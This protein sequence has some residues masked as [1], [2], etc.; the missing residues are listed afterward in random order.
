MPQSTKPHI[1]PSEDIHRSNFLI[2]FR[3]KIGSPDEREL[4]LQVRRLI[5]FP[6]L[7]TEFQK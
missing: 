4:T 3:Y 6:C 2:L 5:P 7:Q 1:I